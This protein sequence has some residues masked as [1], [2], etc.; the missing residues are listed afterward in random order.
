M[1]IYIFKPTWLYIKQH[2]VTRKLYFGKTACSYDEML[3]YRGSGTYWLRHIKKHG[4]EYVETLWFCL[5]YDK[6]ECVDFAL[7][8]SK[9]NNIVESKDWANQ[10]DENGLWGAP[11]GRKATA[12]M[13]G[14]THSESTLEKMRGPFTEEHK[15]NISLAKKGVPN[16][17]AVGKPGNRVGLKNSVAHNI[18]I[19]LANAGPQK[20][21]EC[22]HCGK[23]GGQSL[24]TRWHFNNCRNR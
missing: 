8:F 11:K 16:L 23:L 13:T 22:P 2:S 1:S 3:A 4:K 6:D 21:V 18:A 12:G 20:I 19:G 17:W 15:K 14:Q 5:F 7:R 10:M 24:M 9:N